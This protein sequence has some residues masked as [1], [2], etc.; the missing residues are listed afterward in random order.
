MFM[1]RR[2]VIVMSLFSLV[3]S[4]LIF[5]GV[6][7]IVYALNPTNPFF[8]NLLIILLGSL[9]VS[10]IFAVRQFR[11]LGRDKWRSQIFHTFF[12]RTFLINFVIV[13]LISLVM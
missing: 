3:V 4:F 7:Y 11:Y 2:S 12:I 8:A 9:I 1:G 5:I 6:R 10:F 13:F